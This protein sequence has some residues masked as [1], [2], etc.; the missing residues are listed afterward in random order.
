MAFQPMGNNH[1]RA[2][3]DTAP[4]NIKKIAIIGGDAFAQQM[5]VIQLAEKSRKN[6]LY[7]AI[8]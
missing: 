2:R 6:A 4:V 5:I 3:A 1:Q 8:G 7:I